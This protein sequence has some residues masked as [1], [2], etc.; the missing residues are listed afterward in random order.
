VQAVLLTL[1]GG[2]PLELR[3]KEGNVTA[4]IRGDS[5]LLIVGDPGTG[6]SQ[7]SEGSGGRFPDKPQVSA[8][9]VGRLLTRC[10]PPR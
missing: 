1:I 7:V 3:D 10:A 5:H 8:V 6:K 2:V 4:R 9:G